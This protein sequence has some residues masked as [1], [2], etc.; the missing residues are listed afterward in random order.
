MNAVPTGSILR[1]A[2]VRAITGLSKSTIYAKIAPGQSHDAS[3]PRPVRLGA[4][5]V[6]WLASDVFA[7]VEARPQA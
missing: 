4:R 5:A 2:Q 6:G 1:M 3:F 7:W